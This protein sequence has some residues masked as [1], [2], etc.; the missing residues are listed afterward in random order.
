MIMGVA[1]LRLSRPGRRPG[2]LAQKSLARTV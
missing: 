2:A 1:A